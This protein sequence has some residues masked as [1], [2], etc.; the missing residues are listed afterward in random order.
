MSQLRHGAERA[1]SRDEGFCSAAERYG[2]EHTVECTERAHLLKQS[3]PS[4]E[5]GPV[6]HR[7]RHQKLSVCA[8]QLSGLRSVPAPR[9]HMDE[10]LNDFG[11][12]RRFQ[13]SVAHRFEDS[14]VGLGELRIGT[15]RVRKDR[16]VED[17]HARPE[18]SSSSSR[19][20]SR[21]EGSS[22]RR[23]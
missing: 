20:S 12:R 18:R 2:R 14:E 13:S 5:L 9:V 21:G 19:R 1:I 6:D 4:L 7:K 11:R 3:Q 16:R 8:S 22:I 10:L 17:D 15:D 23:A